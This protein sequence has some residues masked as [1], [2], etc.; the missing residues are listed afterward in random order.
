[1]NQ[2]HCGLARLLPHLRPRKIRIPWNVEAGGFRVDEM[3]AFPP[4]RHDG[5]DRLSTRWA[6]F[7]KQTRF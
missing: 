6:I 1:M 4:R 3:S 7:G 5:P 2:D